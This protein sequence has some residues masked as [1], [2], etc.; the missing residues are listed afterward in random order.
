MSWG[1]AISALYTSQNNAKVNRLV[2]YA[3]VWLRQT[4]SL[5]DTGGEL[6]AYRTVT[7]DAAI[8]RRRTG[9]PEGKEPQPAAWMNAWV[10]ATF[11]SDP[12]GS[13]QNPRFVRAPSGVVLDGR[14]Y[15]SAGKP[16][17]KFSCFWTSR[18]RCVRAGSRLQLV[19]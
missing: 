18:A 15:W 3:P 12:V 19:P 11:A 9:I 8:K 6:G 14:E 13:K 16:L 10:D 7:V 2:L 1:T 5:T 17:R 4:K